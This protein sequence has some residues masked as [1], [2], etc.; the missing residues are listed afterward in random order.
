MPAAENRFMDLVPGM[1]DHIKAL[2]LGGVRGVDSTGVNYRRTVLRGAADSFS[3][4]DVTLAWRIA[5]LDINGRLK[6]TLSKDPDGRFRLRS[7]ANQI[8]P[9]YTMSG[10]IYKNL[11]DSPI[12]I[13]IP[14]I[15]RRF[16]EWKTTLA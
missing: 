6:I 1:I 10:K 5:L 3:P 9:T 4:R 7:P 14:A 2:M 8:I 15:N 11:N 13:D 12:L 16:E